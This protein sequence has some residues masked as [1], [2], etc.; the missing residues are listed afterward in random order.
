MIASAPKPFFLWVHYFDPHFS[1]IRHPEFQFAA[2]DYHGPLP[3][4]ITERSVDDARKESELRAS[5]ISYVEDIY[6]EEI[7]HTDRAIGRLID[8]ISAVGLAD[9][10][11]YI[12]TADHGEYFME[13]G[14][15]FHG[16]D[17][18][19]ELVRVPLVIGGA[20]DSRLAGKVVT[21]PVETRSIAAT[22]MALAGVEEH[23]YRGQ[24]LLAVARS[25][26][27]E[28]YAFSEGS[29]G[30]GP[31]TIKIA[32]VG[33]GW[34]LIHV[35]EGDRYE[36]YDLA[37]DPSERKN[38][39][40]DEDPDTVEVRETLKNA[41]AKLSLKPPEAAAAAGVGDE[42]KAQL[43]ALGYGK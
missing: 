41:L 30:R 5:D 20:L 17:V 10:V 1:Y 19:N 24:D 27:S 23:D 21:A 7:A 28:P 13:R 18:Y 16:R 38:R 33:H 11:V 32:I 26:V 34:K 25:G 12:F 43:R 4:K 40:D 42:Q 8:G 39:I 9:E 3:V 14:R 22:A 35:F 2:D 15:F 31:G 36:L 6:D 37:R 29:A